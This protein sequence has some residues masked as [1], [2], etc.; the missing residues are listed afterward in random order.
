MARWGCIQPGPGRRRET[1]GTEPIAWRRRA[2]PIEESLNSAKLPCKFQS[3]I[4]SAT[5]V[6]CVLV[7]VQPDPTARLADGEDDARRSILRLQLEEGRRLQQRAELAQV[8][9][10]KEE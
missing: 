4:L 8:F 10:P 3:K 6:P 5:L 7:R 2:L 1:R 9:Y